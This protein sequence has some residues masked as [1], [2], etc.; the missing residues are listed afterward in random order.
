[1]VSIPYQDL[2]YRNNAAGPVDRS[3]YAI[4]AASLLLLVLTPLVWDWEGTRPIKLSP[5]RRSLQCRHAR[6]ECPAEHANC[7]FKDSRWI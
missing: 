4:D 7:R 2:H 3:I 1:M 5:N 6:N